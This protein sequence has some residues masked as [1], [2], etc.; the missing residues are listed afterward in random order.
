M[1]AAALRST[2]L[3][4]CLALAAALALPAEAAPK[5][6]LPKPRPIARHSV[7]ATAAPDAVPATTAT[8]SAAPRAADKNGLPVPLQTAHA[9]S[10][11]PLGPPPRAPSVSARKSITPAAV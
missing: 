4:T 3:A 2:A 8:T 5:I 6:P 10:A 9:P 7:V 11:A 1:R